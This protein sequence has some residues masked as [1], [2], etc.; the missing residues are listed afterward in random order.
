MFLLIKVR[1]FACSNTEIIGYFNDEQSY[2]KW[3]S[4]NGYKQNMNFKDQ[5][6]Y[7]KEEEHDELVWI[8]M[9]IIQI[10]NLGD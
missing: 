7:E 2:N 6:I 9:E 3:L 8:Y 10:K 5:F 1:S 4:D